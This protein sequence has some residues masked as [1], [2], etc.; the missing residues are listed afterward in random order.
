[1]KTKWYRPVLYIC[2]QFFLKVLRLIPRT[3]ALN[4]ARI[5]A[6]VSFWVVVRE[7]KKTIANLTNAFDSIY[8][9]KEIAHIAQNVFKHS[10]LTACDFALFPKLT[11]E[12][13]RDMVTFH[14]I[15]KLEHIVRRQAKGGIVLTAHIG[16]WELLGAS[17][18]KAGY[19]GPVIAKEIYYSGYNN[20]IHSLRASQGVEIVYRGESPKSMLQTLKKGGLIGILPDQDIEGIDGIFVDFFGKPAYTPTGPAKL[21]ITARVPII[22]MFMIRNNNRYDLYVEDCIEATLQPDEDK[23]TAIH[24]IT[25]EWNNCIEQYIKKYPEQWAWMHNRWKTKQ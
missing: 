13:V 7:R 2:A 20:L 9:P 21:A 1:V 14:G 18:N 16:N 17:L 23:Q 24:R 11:A 3:V 22:P 6:R 8:T 10:A 4:M 15:E 25:R 12:D 5:I 19:Y